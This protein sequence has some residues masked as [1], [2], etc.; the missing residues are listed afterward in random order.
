VWNDL[1]GRY[2]QQGAEWDEVQNWLTPTMDP[3]GVHYF[4][5]QIW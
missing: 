3:T 5:Y 4:P 2:Y 1:P